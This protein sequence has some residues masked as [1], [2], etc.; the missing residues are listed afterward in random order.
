MSFSAKNRRPSGANAM[1]DGNERSVATGS[2]LSAAVA[3]GWDVSI[4]S[5]T[6]DSANVRLSTERVW[7]GCA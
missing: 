7:H 3:C 2:R 4:A 5:Q 6:S 1:F